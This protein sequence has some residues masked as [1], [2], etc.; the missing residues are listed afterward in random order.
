MDITDQPVSVLIVDD[1]PAGLLALEAMLHAPNRRLVTA[2]SGREALRHLLQEDFAVILLDVHMPEMDGYQTAELIRQRERSR[3]T[4]ILFLTAANKTQEHID[5]GYEVGAFDYVLKPIAPEILKT[6]VNVF[7]ELARKSQQLRDQ[8]ALLLLHSQQMSRGLLAVSPDAMLVTDLHGEIRETNAEAESLS[9]YSRE[10]LLGARALQLL[11]EASR[12]PWLDALK[13]ETPVRLELRCRRK[14]GREVPVDVRLSPIAGGVVTAMRDVSAYKRI[15]V[16]L[17]RSNR[18]LQQFAY[19]AS[20]DLRA[21][22]RA[23][24]SLG[25]MLEDDLQPVLSAESSEH[26]RL[27][28]ARVRRMNGLLNDLLDYAQVGHGDAK[29]EQVDL[30]ALLDEVAELSNVPRGFSLKSPGQLP[31]VTTSPLL[32]KRVLLNLVSN[33]LKH[34]D[35]PE[36]MVQIHVE[37]NG[38]SLLFAVIDDGPGIAPE[39]HERIFQLFQ[40]LKSRD[41]VEG[42]GMGLA[43][44]RKIVEAAGGELSLKS[45]GRGTTFQFSWPVTVHRSADT[46]RP[47][48]PDEFRLD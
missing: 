22:L 36:G 25:S 34:H 11:T 7:V 24:E 35:R 13:S 43:L 10:E 39:F 38:P 1:Q 20:H 37:P 42:S 40:T 9:G 31:T 14:D 2:G 45:E 15:Q 48:R 23:I 33:A 12:V 26:L 28:R 21:P 46:P 18:E 5:R 19:V 41:E 17:E 47:S 6:K 29:P 30:T 8:Q 27:L 3:D 4:P 44:V 16:E 32:L